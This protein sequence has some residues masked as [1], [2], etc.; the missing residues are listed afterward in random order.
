MSILVAS[1]AN[2]PFNRDLLPWIG[3]LAIPA[4]LP[5]GDLNFWGVWTDWITTRVCIERKKLLD[6]VDCVL[7]SGRH[8]QQVQDAHGAGFEFIYIIVEGIFR[9][10]P[11]T[12]LIEVRKGKQ[13]VPMSELSPNNR[14]GSI[15]D[16]EYSRLDSYLN[17]LDL[18]LNV[19]HKHSSGPIETARMAIDLYTLFQKPPEY[20]TSLRQYYHPPDIYA[21]FLSRPSLIRKIISQFEGVGWAKALEFEKYFYNAS[22]LLRAISE[23][24]AVSLR[25]VPGIGKVLADRIIEEAKHENSDL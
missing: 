10:S 15:P 16:L 3:D 13:W 1:A 5:Y 23:S 19:R 8:M 25:A 4:S 22:Y 2:D 24:D 20:H 21:S 12:G 9:P 14:K 18:Y 11:A 7:N 6:I 17:Q